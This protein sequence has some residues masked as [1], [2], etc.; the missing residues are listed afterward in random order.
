MEDLGVRQVQDGNQ[1]HGRTGLRQ[2]ASQAFSESW[3]V[4]AGRGNEGVRTKEEGGV[5]FLRTSAG[6]GH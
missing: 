3:N 5:S 2:R 1:G 4:D 6:A